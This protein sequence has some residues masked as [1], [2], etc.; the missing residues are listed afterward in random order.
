MSTRS[1][2]RWQMG[3]LGAAAALMLAVGAAGA[4]GTYTNVVSEFHRQAT[5]AGVVAAGEGLTLVLA[6]IMLGRTMLGQSSP[7]VVRLG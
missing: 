1:L 5:A 3:V 2:T 4:S 6:L 7:A